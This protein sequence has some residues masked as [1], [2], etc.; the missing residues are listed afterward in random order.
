MQKDGAAF[1]LFLSISIVSASSLAY[2]IL[3]MRLFSIVQWHHFAYMVISLA[4]LG[5]GVSG[6]FITLLRKQLFAHFPK[7]YI[8]NLLFFASSA[9]TAFFIAQHIPF[10]AQE[11]LLDPRGILWLLLYFLLFSLPFFFAANAVGLALSFYRKEISGLYA[12]DMFGAGLGSFAILLLFYHFHPTTILQMVS[13]FG[14]VA[15]VLASLALKTGKLT[16]LFLLTATLLP[17]FLPNDFK[18]IRISPYKGLSQTLQIKGTRIVDEEV[19]PMGIITV[20][21]SP[22]I[23]FRYAP[24]VSLYNETEPPEQLGLFVNGEWAGVITRYPQNRSGLKYL[25]YLTSALAYHVTDPK[26]VLI[27]GADGGM[28]VLQALFHDVEHIDGVEMD[29][30]IVNL[31][32]V[33]YADF[34]GHIYEKPNVHIDVDDARG[35]I[36]KNE[37]KYDLIQFALPGPDGGSSSG[38]SALSEDYL[39]TVE[40]FQSYLKYLR[41]GGYLSITRWIKLP[42]RDSLKLVT[43][44][45]EAFERRGMEAPEKRLLLIR[46]WQTTTLL[47]K[48]GLVH[49]REIEKMKAF[50]LSRGFD[51]IYYYGM[52]LSEAN[53]FNIL[54]H[55]I[56]HTSVTNLLEDPGFSDRYRF[57][58]RPATDDRPYF[59]HF[60][61][62]ESFFDIL[63]LR[64]TGGLYLMEWGY[65]ILVATLL[66]A[67]VLS[68][69]LILLPL[70]VGTGRLKASRSFG[71]NAVL[72]YF[73]MLGI[74]FM[75]LEIA[76]IQ[77]FVLFISHPIFSAAIVLSTFL[78]FAGM[79]SGFSHSLIAKKGD[80]TTLK[81]SIIAI[82]LF[83]L[84]DLLILH[85]FHER[86]VVLPF[87]IKTA[88]TVITLAPLAF[89][90]GIPFPL[91]LSFLASRNAPLVPWAWG[92]NGCASVISAILASLLAVHLGFTIVIF[93]AL[94]LYV[95]TLF[96]FPKK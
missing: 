82:V 20:V 16:T 25:D 57:D 77:K 14:I 96:V 23:P 22:E 88:L 43:T 56:F 2:E 9:P 84:S 86:F 39:F 76:F 33:R 72:A 61:T 66:L 83:T 11:M 5:Y 64:E 17:F 92:V 19:G 70:L 10:N 40:A 35:F 29:A 62:W 93:L 89:S 45:M 8:L 87:A 34:S 4:L 26:N 41:P 50:C 32:K 51:P 37:K 44:A 65:L 30:T 1:T 80:A 42:P 90:M 27:V 94:C 47:I 55:P 95:G 3:V 18:E 52:P 38:L 6:T 78:L 59:H 15:A 63:S 53:R 21:E 13:T 7:V 75:F 71:K 36:L 68:I 12:A 28:D 74:A 81:I 91:G 31:V 48:N 60:F 67:V 69:V 54:E 58:I 85:Y 46:G 73:F 49:D 79:G 24:G